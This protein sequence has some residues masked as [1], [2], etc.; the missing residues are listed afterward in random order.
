MSGVHRALSVN[1][2]FNLSS[3][4]KKVCGC[5]YFGQ[6]PLQPWSKH[7]KLAYLSPCLF[8]ATNH[9][10]NSIA[11]FNDARATWTKHVLPPCLLLGVYLCG[12]GNEQA[13][14]SMAKTIVW[15]TLKSRKL[16]TAF[17]DYFSRHDFCSWAITFRLAHFGAM[18]HSDASIKLLYLFC[19]SSKQ[20]FLIP[21]LN[22]TSSK[23]ANVSSYFSQ[24][25]GVGMWILFIL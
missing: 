13:S 23:L 19:S 6:L 22:S 17:P 8:E 3:F 14:E 25:F 12:R 10:M 15:C 4:L 9:G 1:A 21:L 20:S 16:R 18:P 24:N 2:V 5:C 7:S 11:I